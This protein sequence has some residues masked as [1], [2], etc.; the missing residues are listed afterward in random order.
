MHIKPVS[1]S[2]FPSVWVWAL[3]TQSRK[4]LRHRAVKRALLLYYH[5]WDTLKCAITVLCIAVRPC[6]SAFYGISCGWFLAPNLP[7]VCRREVFGATCAQEFQESTSNMLDVDTSI[8]CTVNLENAV[9]KPVKVFLIRSSTPDV[10]KAFR[11]RTDNCPD[12]TFLNLTAGLILNAAVFFHCAHTTLLRF[13]LAGW[14]DMPSCLS[15][16]RL[17]VVG[18]DA[19]RSSAVEGDAVLERRQWDTDANE[20]LA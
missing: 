13:W 7:E 2:T 19:N 5:Y 15:L 8:R 12:T 9:T 1:L 6:K 18:S 16:R 10:V 4:K 14:R 3:V 20:A 11:S 17:C